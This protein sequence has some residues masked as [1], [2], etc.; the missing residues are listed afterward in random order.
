M[1]ASANAACVSSLTFLGGMGSPD[2][3]SRRRDLFRKQSC[4]P[5]PVRSGATFYYIAFPSTWT[6]TI[7]RNLFDPHRL[8]WPLHLACTSFRTPVPQRGA[9]TTPLSSLFTASCG[10]VVSTIPPFPCTMSSN[11]P[12]LSYL[13][14]DD[15]TGQ[16]Q[17][18]PHHPRQ[19][20]GLSW[21]SPLR[22]RRPRPAFRPGGQ[23]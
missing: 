22:R 12:L 13:L 6:N 8:I 2:I 7:H 11:S 16:E 15:T 14:Q 9:P 19:P 17:E 23:Q 10:T 3:S 21:R 4:L 1:Q 5:F 20:T 18:C